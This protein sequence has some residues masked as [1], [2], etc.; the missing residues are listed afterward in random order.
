[1]ALVVYHHN[2]MD[3]KAA[4]YLVHSMKPKEIEDF[5]ENYHMCT[6]DDAFDKHGEKDD[7]FIVDLSISRNTYPDLL[8]VCKTARTV[9]WID[10]HQSSVDVIKEH[11]DE[12]QAIKNL[13]YFVSNGLCGAALVYCYFS[14]PNDELKQIRK[15]EDREKYSIKAEYKDGGFVTVDMAKTDRSDAT[16]YLWFSHDLSLPNWIFHID[17]YDCWKKLNDAT[18]K[19]I[20]G[21]ECCDT[22]LTI[23]NGSRLMFNSFWEEVSTDIGVLNKHIANGRVI[24]KYLNRRYTNELPLTFEWECDGTKFLCKSCT[25]NSWNFQD[26]INNYPAVILFEYDGSHGVWVYSVYAADSST[27]DCGKFAEQFGGGGHFHAAGFSTKKLIFTSKQY[28]Y[29]KKKENVIFLGGTTNDP[30]WRSRFINLW[31][32]S[33][34]SITDEVSLFN[35]IV[36]DWTEECIKK[37]NEVKSTARLNLFLIRPDMMKGCYS[38]IE[39]TECSHLSKVFFAVYDPG[40]TM[41]EGSIRSFKAIGDIIE[42]NGGKFKIYLNNFEDGHDSFDDFVNDVIAFV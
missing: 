19:F 7:V 20:L 39:A 26:M 6:Y 10:H 8:E 5:P 25:G 27:F 11:E 33:E 3:G 17:D 15:T 2:D 34:D 13:T 14:L 35:P 28:N 40:L 4:G 16:Q 18:D 1:M 22:N 32:K 30:D 21:T 12:L 31:K 37:E 24:D 29:F 41:D 36:E 9:T 23:T 42:E 38:L